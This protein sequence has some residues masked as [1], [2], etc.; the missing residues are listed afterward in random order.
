MA[1]NDRPSFERLVDHVVGDLSESERGGVERAIAA[2]PALRA[3][4]DAIRRVVDAARE[5][6]GAS[7]PPAARLRARPLL[8]Q[9]RTAWLRWLDDAI[10]STVRAVFDS[11]ATPALAGFRG[12]AETVQLAYESDHGRLD[13]SVGGSAAPAESRSVRGQVTPAGDATPGLVMAVDEQRAIVGVAHADE[14]GE[15]AFAAPIGTVELIVELD[16]GRAAM[17]VPHL[18]IG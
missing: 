10:V 8:G 9:R 13:L 18:E 4:V 17:R 16:D 2:S 14:H 1:S 6:D 3:Q 12:G 5:D 7:A 15:F 11:R